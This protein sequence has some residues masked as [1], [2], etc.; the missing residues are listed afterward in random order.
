MATTGDVSVRLEARAGGSVARVTIDNQRQ[1]NTLNTPLMMAFIEDMKALG[2][3]GE[4]RAVVLTGAGTRAFIG[5]ADIR[6]IAALDATTARA[7]IGR[8]HECCEVLRALPVPVI[9]RMEGYALGAGME[10]A[11]ACDLRIASQ[12]AVFGMPEVKLGI[13]SVVEAALLPM[14]IGWGRTRQL[15]LL[16]ETFTAAEAQDWG[17]VERMVPADALDDALEEWLEALLACGPQAIRLQKRLIRDW[18]S[19]S[20]AAAVEAGIEAFVAAWRSDEPK[21]AMREFLAARAARK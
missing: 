12:S 17:F 9:A 10:V 8:V 14:L 2:A 11:A 21:L 16:G 20:P 1:L 13:P 7:F 4:L 5:G 18:E 15:L 6:E 19:L 3:L